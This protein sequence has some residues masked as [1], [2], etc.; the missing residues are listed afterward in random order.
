MST[1]K[2]PLGYNLVTLMKRL[3]AATSRLEDLTLYQSEATNNIKSEKSVASAPPPSDFDSISPTV[4]KNSKSVQS[5]DEV[6][7]IPTISPEPVSAQAESLGPLPLSIIEFDEYLKEYVAPFVEKSKDINPLVYEQAKLYAAAFEAEHDFLL[8]ASKSKKPDMS[9]PVF[10]ELLTPISDNISKLNEIRENNRTS[11]FSNHLATVAEG[12]ASIGWIGAQSS[13]APM[14]GDFKEG[15][16]FYGN[17][18]LKEYRDVDKKHAEWVKLYFDTF[19]GLQSYVKKHH[20]TGVTWNPEG[21]AVQEVLK[22]FKI[23]ESSDPSTVPVPALISV[24]ASSGGPPPPP[25]P[26]PAASVFEVNLSDSTSKSAAPSGG[27]DALF[28]EISKGESVT[29]SLKKVDKSQMTH[30][31][32]ELRASSEVPVITKKNPVPPKKPS[33][34]MQKQKK[35]AKTE[36]NGTKWIIENYDDSHEIVIEAEIS[37]GIFIDNCNNSTIQIKGKANAITINN[38]SKIGVLVESL[39]SSADIIK[40]KSFG[41]QITGM[42]PIVTVD[43]SDNGQIYLSKQSLDTEIYTSQTTSLNIN[44]PDDNEDGEFNEVPLPEQLCHKVGANGKVT[45]TVVEHSS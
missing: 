33:S 27:M 14:I 7:E 24:G 25:P 12:A 13:P 31:N 18:V 36:L 45:T 44:I 9:D 2:I 40:S 26:M 17:R 29:S 23:G 11:K 6:A 4:S 35:P 41:L 43:Q 5:S 8:I 28:A 38:C 34:L 22:D 39:V 19:S 16:E 3:E 32:P 15:A 42:A 10:M 21:H 20:T 37:Q 1:E 30:K